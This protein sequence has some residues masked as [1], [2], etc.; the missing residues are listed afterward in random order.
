MTSTELEGKVVLVTG[1]SR[2][3][4]RAICEGLAD[5]GAT[6][7]V[8][9][10]KQPA[11]EEVA[12]QITRRTGRRAWGI[13]MHVGHWDEIEAVLDRVEGGVGPIDVLVNNAG[14]APGSPSLAEQTEALFD[15]TIEINLKGPFRLMA[16]VGARM[17]R[18]GA[19]SIVNISSIGSQ[20]PGNGE[21]TYA[22]AKAGLNA[23]TMAFAQ[24]YAPEVRVNAVLPGAF[25]TDMSTGWDEELVS[26]TIDRLPAGRMGQPEE[27][28]GAVLYLAGDGAAYTTGALL[29]VDGGRT[30][31][32]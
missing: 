32:Y 31:L 7:V 8:S 14:I 3:L 2:G 26:R 28:V 6:V 27:I 30:T 5:A 4:G 25:A 22:A 15:K 17:K 10:R 18:R 19:G 29:N 16:L 12:E 1:G 21:A 24:E 23:L 13:P 9:S 20:R 11:C